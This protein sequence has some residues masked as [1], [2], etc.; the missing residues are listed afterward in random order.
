MLL[1]VSELFA[2]VL[3]GS[4][5]FLSVLVGLVLDGSELFLWSELWCRSFGV[6]TLVLEVFGS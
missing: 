3:V 2:S 4:V 5:L 1:F 6:G